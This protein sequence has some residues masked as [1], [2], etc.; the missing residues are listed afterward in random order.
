MMSLTM[1]ANGCG[2]EQKAIGGAVPP[3]TSPGTL[4][5]NL[6]RL[7]RHHGAIFA[8]PGER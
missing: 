8:N 1:N 3:S 7:A 2:Y 4:A 6:S 5:E